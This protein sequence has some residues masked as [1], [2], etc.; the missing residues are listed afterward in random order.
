MKRLLAFSLLCCLLGPAHA[1]EKAVRRVLDD[2]HKAASQ[3]DGPRYFNH[4]APEGVFLGTDASE[5]WNV[6]QF[7]AYAMPHFSKG[8]GWTYTST[9]RNITLSPD[10]NLAWFDEALSNA[11][12]G[13]TRGS[14]VL[15]LINGEWKICQ[16]NLSVPVP[17]DLLGEVVKMIRARQNP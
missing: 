7:R 16:Y 8:Q 4:F 5:R 15:R 9:A 1:D 10:G 17:N 13:E 11:N 14:G 3:A 2:F 12:Y 6:E